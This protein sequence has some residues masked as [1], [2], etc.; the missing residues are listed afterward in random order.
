MPWCGDT[1]AVE[2]WQVDFPLTYGGE[3]VVEDLWRGRC[4]HV[5]EVIL[6]GGVCVLLPEEGEALCIRDL[7]TLAGWATVSG[8]LPGSCSWRSWEAVQQ[9]GLVAGPGVERWTGRHH[10]G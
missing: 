6:L 8:D 1:G 2:G 4:A 7:K 5:M 3:K 9:G 10:H